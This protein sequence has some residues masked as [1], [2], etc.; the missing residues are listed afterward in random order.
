MDQQASWSKEFQFP[1]ESGSWQQCNIVAHS[2]GGSRP[3]CSA[4]AWV[5]E[6][7]MIVESEW[8]FK[9]VACGGKYIEPPVFSFEAESIALELCTNYVKT[10]LEK[11]L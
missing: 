9:Q 11:L 7:G 4:A 5:V 10:S 8:V 3:S 6:V 1:F 2:D